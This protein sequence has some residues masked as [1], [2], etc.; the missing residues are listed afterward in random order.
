ME[1]T[2]E[3]A[4]TGFLHQITEPRWGVGDTGDKGSAASSGEVVGGHPQLPQIGDGGSVGG[5]APNI[6]SMSKVE[7]LRGGVQEVPMAVS[8]GARN[9]AQP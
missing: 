5:A 1:K 7:R 4:D 6:Q 3:W 8:E 9:V 2:V